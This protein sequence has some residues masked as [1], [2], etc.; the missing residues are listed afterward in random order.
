MSS[1][2]HLEKQ[3]YGKHYSDESKKGNEMGILNDYPAMIKRIE[4]QVDKE[5][6]ER[7]RKLDHD[8]RIIE[9]LEEQYEVL[10][11]QN[12]LLKQLIERS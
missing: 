7:N 12:G 5:I 1:M 3:L 11:E 6:A 8:A 4:R 10:Q 9:L 2:L